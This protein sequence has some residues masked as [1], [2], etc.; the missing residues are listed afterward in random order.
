VEFLCISVFLHLVHLLFTVLFDLTMTFRQFSE[1]LSLDTP[2]SDMP[3]LLQALWH[4]EKGDWEEAH[5]IAQSRE[6]TRDYDRL[7][8]YLHRVEGDDWN[9]GYWYR[10]AGVKVYKGSLKEEWTELVH[11][12]L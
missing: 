9:A 1:S 2:P 6:G 4:D 5:N 7:H 12:L 11:E 3:I 10:R 8:A